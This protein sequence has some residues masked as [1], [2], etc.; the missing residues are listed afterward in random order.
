MRRVWKSKVAALVIALF[1]MTLLVPE[2]SF[3]Q[4]VDKC[5]ISSTR[6]ST[7]SLGFP[8][9]P[10]RLSYI[11]SPKILVIPFA[12]KDGAIYESDFL[13]EK[14]NETAQ[15]IRKLSSNLANIKFIFTQ[16]VK[17][18]MSTSEL[19]DLKLN[20]PKVYLKDFENDQMGFAQKVIK[21]LDAQIDYT[22]IDGVVL[23]GLSTSKK[24]E[25]ASALQFTDDPSYV[26]NDTKRPDGQN[27][28]TPIK[29]NEKVISNVVL[30]YNRSESRVLTHEILHNYGLTDL[31]GSEKSPPF[32][33]MSTSVKTLA[34]LPFEKWILGWLPDRNVICVD[35]KTEI[36]E[37]LEQNSFVIDYSKG[38]HTL[39][40][41]TGL[42]TALVIE[43]LTIDKEVYLLYYSLDN[44]KRP[45][46][47]IFPSLKS[48]D[49]SV[50]LTEFAGI[51]ELLKSPEYSLLIADNTGS[52]V[53]LNLIPSNQIGSE[54][55]LKL[56]KDSEVKKVERDILIKARQEA[57]AKAAVPKKITITCVKGK[58]VKKVTATKPKC[59]S[60]YKKK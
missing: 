39:V 55:S 10:E 20:A 35:A 47:Q 33:L 31:Y 41:P 54:A 43:V 36:L 24:Q 32:S 4:S 1:S 51:T 56:I 28:F 60:G 23:F 15:D 6:Y 45:A 34:L 18:S 44:D 42:A 40:I 11:P 9:R 12:A 8:V 58:T 57:E 14:F 17:L 59:P 21:D 5:R 13:I 49:G 7:L 48:R 53:A 30:M 37:N 29:T 52:S 22:G 46:I 50:A 19:D 2:K 3:A 25:I 16:T 27:W 26:G 38:D